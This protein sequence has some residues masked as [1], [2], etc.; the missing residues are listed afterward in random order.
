MSA[1]IGHDGRGVTYV[2]VRSDKMADSLLK[3][4][5]KERKSFDTKFPFNIDKAY[6]RHVI[7]GIIDGDGSI[8][9]YPFVTKDG[10]HKFAHSISCCGSHRLMT[11][12]V[13]AIS[14]QLQLKSTPKVYDYKKRVLSEFRISRIE[15]V[16][17]FGDWLYAD[18]TIFLKRK[19]FNYDLI[20]DHYS[21]N[22]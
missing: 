22:G 11:E 17:T 9:A 1:N 3:Y 16:K 5:L 10:R 12:M 7:R 6:Y 21:L 15:D 20:V 4:G 18:A 13:S 19:K 2:A 8:Q 14:D